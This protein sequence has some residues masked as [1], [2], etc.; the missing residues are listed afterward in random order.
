M[1]RWLVPYS[2]P[3]REL[4]GDRAGLKNSAVLKMMRERVRADMEA[5]GEGQQAAEIEVV[6]PPMQAALDLS[7]SWI[8]EPRLFVSEPSSRA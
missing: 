6:G 5:L 7:S 3:H 4:A 8:L 2:A 1:P